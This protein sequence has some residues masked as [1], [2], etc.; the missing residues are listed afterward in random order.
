MAAY[1]GRVEMFNALFGDGGK[2]LDTTVPKDARGEP[3]TMT[4]EVFDRMFGNNDDFTRQIRYKRR[5]K[6]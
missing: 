2:T 6:S 1:E 5:D 3:L 4:P